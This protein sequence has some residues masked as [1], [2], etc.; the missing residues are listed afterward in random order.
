MTARVIARPHRDLRAAD[1]AL[2]SDALLT[3]AHCVYNVKF[4]GWARTMRVVPGP[5]LAGVTQQPFGSASAK[6]GFVPEAYRAAKTFWAREPYDYAVVRVGAG[7]VGAPGVR[8]F[9][10]LPSPMLGRAIRLTGYHGDKCAG[11]VRCTPGSSSY[12]MQQSKHE[13]RELLPTDAARY[14]LFNHFADSNGGASGSPI[15]SDGDYANTIFAVHVAGFQDIN[16]ASWNMGVLLTPTSV[17]H[18]KSWIRQTL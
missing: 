1:G 2:A 3:A 12:V 13:I 17:T 11:N 4:G 7:L 16:A 6:R 15:I 10:A 8:A 9:A 5:S 18:I 14:T